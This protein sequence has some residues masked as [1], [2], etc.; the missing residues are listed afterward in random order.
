MEPHTI[1]LESVCSRAIQCIYKQTVSQPDSV[2]HEIES[3]CLCKIRSCTLLPYCDKYI[4]DKAF[5]DPSFSRSA[6]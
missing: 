6:L 1:N 5:M 2:L 4:S 3:L